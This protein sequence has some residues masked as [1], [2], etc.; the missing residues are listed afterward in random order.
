MKSKIKINK[1]KNPIYHDGGE[2]PIDNGL[3]TLSILTF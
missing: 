1:I 3:T 2:L